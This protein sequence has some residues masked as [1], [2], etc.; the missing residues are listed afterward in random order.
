M[1][2]QRVVLCKMRFFISARFVYENEVRGKS[3]KLV[4]TKGS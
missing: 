3:I 4:A 2:V 1:K